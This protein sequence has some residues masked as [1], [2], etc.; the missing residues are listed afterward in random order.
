MTGNDELEEEKPPEQPKQDNDILTMQKEIAVK[1]KDIA[2]A[3]L[4]ALKAQFPPGESKPI[5]G[6][7][8]TDEKSGY[9]A[10]LV[11]YHAMIETANI[12]AGKINNLSLSEE[13]RLIIVDSL[14]FC[15]P[16]VQLLQVSSQINFWYSELDGQI[17][18]IDGL[19]PK[20]VKVEEEIEMFGLAPIAAGSVLATGLLSS[21]ADIIGYFRT[22]YEVKGREIKLSDVSLRSLV[23]GRVDK[24]PVYLLNFHRISS[25]DLINRFNTCIEKK[26]L[27]RQSM[28]Q[29]K[30]QVIDV[31]SKKKG[32]KPSEAEI[33]YLRS[34]AVIKEF[35]EFNKLVNSV[36]AGSKYSPLASSV[37]RQY[38]DGI[39]ATHLLYLAVTSSGGD[40]I[41]GR[42]I[43]Q[44]GKVKYLGGCVASFILADCEGKV[45]AADTVIQPSYTK[46]KLGEDRLPV[47]RTNDKSD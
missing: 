20:E 43:W 8:T 7:V 37:I 46:L 18:S 30:S 10:D 5:E 36:P 31:A 41:T 16:E 15:G 12:I 24:C 25:S 45:I 9:V 3:N 6:K 22:D 47:F 39:G 11:A 21:A 42:G 33:I 28:I 17:M 26:K 27:L 14:D 4:A 35:H 40:V 29:L 1:Q 13:S 38:L 2:E 32:E 23:A 44:W 34:E 19:L